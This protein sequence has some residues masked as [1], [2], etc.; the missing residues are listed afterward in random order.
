ML[1]PD[2]VAKKMWEDIK[3]E[4]VLKFINKLLWLEWIDKRSGTEQERV[5]L[6]MKMDNS[7]FW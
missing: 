7:H 4:V 5:M 2:Y 1:E 6:M 3:K